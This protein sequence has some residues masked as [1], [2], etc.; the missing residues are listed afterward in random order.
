MPSDNLAVQLSGFNI[1]DMTSTMSVVPTARPT[2]GECEVLLRISLRPV[3]P[4][5]IFSVMGVYPG[6]KPEGRFPATPG[7]EGM[8]TVVENGPG[9]TKFVAGQRVAGAPFN[10]VEGGSGTW[11]QYMVA[12]EGCLVAVPDAVTDEAAAQFW[13]N[14]VTVFGMLHE[15]AVPQGEWLLQTAAGSVLGRQMIQ[16]AKQRGIRTINVVRRSEQAEELKSLG[17]DEVVVSVEGEGLAE[18]V[19]EITGGRGAYGAIECIGGDIFAQVTSSVRNSGTVII[20]GAMSGLKATF[21]IPD[22][23]FRCVKIQGFWLMPWTDSLP[24]E[25]RACV[26]A[27]VMQLLADGVIT[28]YSGQRFPLERAIE[29]IGVATSAARGG[30]VLLEG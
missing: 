30:K 19:R 26:M 24:T 8:G 25:E 20:Y 2:P 10:T 29:A 7:L 18:R 11:Q 3:N 9:C 22:P 4:A 15:L 1:E 12:R 14:P 23:L 6:F 5:D 21:G 17:A 16:L 27:A 13:V 28:P